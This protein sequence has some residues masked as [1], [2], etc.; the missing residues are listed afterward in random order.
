M[1]W[2]RRM[3]SRP[4]HLLSRRQPSQRIKPAHIVIAG[5]SAS[6][7]AYQRRRVGISNTILKGNRL[8]PSMATH[9][10][11][12]RAD[13]TS[14]VK[15]HRNLHHGQHFQLPPSKGVYS[16]NPSKATV[17]LRKWRIRRPACTRRSRLNLMKHPDGRLAFRSRN[18][19]TKQA[20]TPPR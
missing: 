13:P 8:A 12:G 9:R 1:R 15:N 10:G 3:E 2:R 19:P 18:E 17:E 16:L 7:R 4:L 20:V 6:L 5:L 14:L 11:P